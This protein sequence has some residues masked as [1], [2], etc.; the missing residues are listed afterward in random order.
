MTPQPIRGRWDL[1][2]KNFDASGK[3]EEGKPA[4][5]CKDSTEPAGRPANP[6]AKVS[7]VEDATVR[8]REAS[9]HRGVEP[10]TATTAPLASPS[11]P[12]YPFFIV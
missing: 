3:P 9:I 6:E 4:S 10:L 11:K 7:D 8:L 12:G 2:P 5:L 1:R